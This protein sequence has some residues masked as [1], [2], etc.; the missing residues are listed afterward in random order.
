VHELSIAQSILD[1]VR[2]HVPSDFEGKL[3]SVKVALG[4]HSGVVSESLE[5]CFEAVVSETPFEGT[6]LVM[7]T[8]PVRSECLDC[9]QTFD[10]SEMRQTCVY[11]DGTELRFV[12]GTELHVVEVEVEE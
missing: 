9:H 11:C 1:I 2:Q 6:K 7:Q 3:R 12:T 8:I 10:N 4:E 5:F